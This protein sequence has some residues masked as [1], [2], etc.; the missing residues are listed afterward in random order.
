MSQDIS[1]LCIS[2]LVI[3][4]MK[5]CVKLLHVNLL[6]YLLYSIPWRINGNEIDDMLMNYLNIFLD[7]NATTE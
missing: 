4:V 5:S 1:P 7:L 3:L 6:L 2:H